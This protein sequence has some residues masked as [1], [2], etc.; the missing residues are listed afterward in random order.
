MPELPE[1]ETT[2]RGIEPAVVGRAVTRVVVRD[3]RLRWRVPAALTKEL[4]GRVI[5]AVARRGKYLL[6]HTATGAVILHLGMSGSLRV[7]RCSDPP[8]K[9]DHVDIALDSGDCLRLRDPRRFGAV[10]WTRDHARHRLLARLGVEPLGPE[11][12][13][14][15]LFRATRGRRR[16]IRDFLLDGSVVAGIG[17]IYANEALFAAGIRPTRRAGRLD[18]DQCLRLARAIRATLKKAIRAGGTTLRD[19]RNGRGE[20]GRFQRALRVYGRGGEACRACGRPIRAL[21]LGQR[22]AFFCPRCQQ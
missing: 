10:L 12:T 9:Y 17:N 7:V 5:G 2:R 16:A 11:F 18:R 13:G 8:G 22:S 6:L 20:P 1:V 19:F 3:P 21:R 14:D 15:Y 4:P